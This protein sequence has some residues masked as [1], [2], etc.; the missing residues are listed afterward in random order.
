M[1]E[2]KCD[3][4]EERKD[5]MVQFMANVEEGEN[6]YMIRRVYCCVSKLKKICEEG[7]FGNGLGDSI[8]DMVTYEFFNDPE[9]A[10]RR[11]G[12][13]YAISSESLERSLQNDPELAIY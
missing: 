9:D 8:I 3:S 13:V 12:S 1:E 11:E 4:C 10:A 5:Y 6:P 2:N 7:N